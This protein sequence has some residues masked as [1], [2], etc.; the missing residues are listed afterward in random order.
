MLLPPGGG[1]AGAAGP[2]SI[3]PPRGSRPVAAQ[4]RSGAPA[5]LGLP[6]PGQPAG[7]SGLSPPSEPAGQGLA[8]RRPRQVGSGDADPARLLGSRTSSRPL[9]GSLEGHESSPHPLLLLFF[10]H[11]V[12]LHRGAEV[13][14]PGQSRAWGLARRPARASGPGKDLAGPGR[15]LRP[16][17]ARSRAG[18]G[19]RSQARL[20]VSWPPLPPEHGQG[21]VGGCCVPRR[22][23]VTLVTR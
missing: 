9:A 19:D 21:A 6:A 2:G 12:G 23:P 11:S 7:G 15:L 14:P 18:P 13:G 3:P 22:S 8:A 20:R 10:S 4:L 16:S 17:W 5:E 1:R